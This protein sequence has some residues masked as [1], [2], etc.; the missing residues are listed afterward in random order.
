M[1]NQYDVFLSYAT[2]DNSMLA[3]PWYGQDRWVMCFKVALQEAIDRQLGRTGD[4][5]WFLDR[6]D[7]RT[8]DQFDTELR[9]AL[10]NTTVLV[11]LAS[12][13]YFNDNSWCKI[14][15]EHFVAT[16]APK[17]SRHGRIFGVLLEENALSLWRQKAFPEL[18]AFS[19]YDKDTAIEASMRFGEGEITARFIQRVSFLA[20]D[21]AQYLGEA[22]VDA[23]PVARLSTPTRG[24]VFLAAVPG[25]MEGERTELAQS[26]AAANWRVIPEE[27]ACDQDIETCK[28]ESHAQARQ[29]FA[30]VQL[31]STHPWKP[32]P[33][34][35]AQFEGAREAGTP[36][37]RFRSDEIDLAKVANVEQRAWLE[38]Y[39]V[40]A[41]SI[42]GI[43]KELLNRLNEMQASLTAA[44]RRAEVTGK[45]LGDQ[46]AEGMHDNATA[47]VTVSV[48]AQ[49]RPTVGE[50]LV[51]RLRE[52]NVYA[53]IPPEASLSFED[54]LL[55][56]HGF[57]TV[58]GNEPYDRIEKALLEW[59]RLLL[60]YR[61]KPGKAPPIGIFLSEPPPGDKRAA[62]NMTLP[63]LRVLPWDD[64]PEFEG[65]VGAV[66]SYVQ[67]LVGK[68]AR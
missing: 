32:G 52:K 31:L 65:F 41:R 56:E 37:F 40:A 49:E 1:S 55:K 25:E 54:C 24:T 11:A 30:F 66:R 17:G 62:I 58:F 6:K 61:P 35:K 42:A 3:K 34:D 18:Q 19:F 16:H 27:N 63:G 64:E 57:L 48:A 23:P 29:S 13:A 51:R 33:Y 47:F 50:A 60:K 5:Q 12:N 67:G 14:E 38:K 28:R 39:D 10:E 21:I 9:S 43:K 2:V 8:G 20:K 45:T 15:R 7:L 4:A 53:L 68:P 22:R 59:R 36:I 46:T 26:L 44:T